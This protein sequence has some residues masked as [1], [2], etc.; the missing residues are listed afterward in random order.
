M[1]IGRSAFVR[2]GFGGGAVENAGGPGQSADLFSARGGVDDAVAVCRSSRRAP[3]SPGAS[4]SGGGRGSGSRQASKT[5]LPCANRPM[6]A[7]WPISAKPNYL[8]EAKPAPTRKP[9]GAPE[10][11]IQADSWLTRNGKVSDIG[12]KPLPF[13]G[14][15]Q[16]ARLKSRPDAER[17]LKQPLRKMLS[18]PSLR[19]HSAAKIVHLRASSS[20]IEL[21][22]AHRN[23]AAGSLPSQRERERRSSV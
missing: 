1:T 19:L 17:F 12:L 9:Y 8:N 13:L 4:W 7:S 16:P 15:V 14:R 23:R 20:R 3:W 22:E 10:N 5:P 11:T 6:T 18:A 2:V 21:R